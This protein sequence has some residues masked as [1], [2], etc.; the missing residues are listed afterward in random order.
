MNV[1][2]RDVYCNY[3]ESISYW[4]GFDQTENRGIFKESVQTIAGRVSIIAA[5]V[6]G[7][8]SV[9]T[10]G[11]LNLLDSLAVGLL[12][13]DGNEL[14]NVT[15][16]L[17]VT[18]FKLINLVYFSLM[19][20]CS[21]TVLKEIFNKKLYGAHLVTSRTKTL[22][23]HRNVLTSRLTGV[24]RVFTKGLGGFFNGLFLLL[25]VPLRIPAIGF[26]ESIKG[27]EQI[28]SPITQ[29]FFGIIGLI[30]SFHL[31]KLDLEFEIEHPSPQV[32]FTSYEEDP[33]VQ[34][35]SQVD[36]DSGVQIDTW[37]YGQFCIDLN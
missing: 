7:M 37:E 10:D 17:K 14:Q 13:F 21:L 34:T 11:A 8:L 33:P 35:R 32:I 4:S 1:H 30:N 28:F 2:P 12:T 31:S 16:S 19:G 20:V 27:V 9:V 18:L 22:M 24:V 36:I 23:R 25:S 26:S 6:L 5:F 3:F 29:L 15:Q